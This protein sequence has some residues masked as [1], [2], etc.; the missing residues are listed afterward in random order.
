ML[1]NNGDEC[2]ISIRKLTQM[3]PDS[4]DSQVSI[5]LRN[6]NSQFTTTWN[7]F[8][9][10][11]VSVNVPLKPVAKDVFHVRP[12]HHIQTCMAISSP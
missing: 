5:L 7:I 6:L 12:K 9:S 1:L 11:H 4:E 8:Q 2:T 3:N 10:L